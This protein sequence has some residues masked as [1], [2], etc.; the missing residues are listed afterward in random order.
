MKNTI[1]GTRTEKNLMAA[2]AGE[3]Q[4]F[5]RYSYFAEAARKEGYEQIANIFLDTANNERT[6]AR[7]FFQYLEGG[8]VEMTAT[9]PS[10]AASDTK[11]NLKAAV[12][13]ENAAWTLHYE[14]FARIAREENFP[15]IAS[16]FKH[17]AVAE[18]FHEDRFK[19]LMDNLGK[20]EVF[21]KNMS[22]KWHC[23]NC[24][25]VLEG[26]EVPRLCPAC[27]SPQAFYE[28]LAENY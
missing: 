5:N 8:G 3:S 11:T 18:K 15:E 20:N 1:K 7:A 22:V 9:F 16:T 28:V 23:T 27:Q 6:H 26:K 2:F 24:G 19:R 4:T 21:K 25:Y 12:A 17:I 13:G 14:D 10:G